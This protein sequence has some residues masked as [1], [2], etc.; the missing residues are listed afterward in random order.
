MLLIRG[1]VFLP[2]VK[3]KVKRK[4]QLMKEHTVE[5]NARGAGERVRGKPLRVLADLKKK[6]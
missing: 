5:N 4:R 1:R 3:T 2:L 6:L